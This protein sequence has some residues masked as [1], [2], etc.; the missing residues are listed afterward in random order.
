LT[1]DALVSAEVVIAN[2]SIVTASATSYPDLFWAL[3]GAGSSF[4]VVTEFKFQTHPAPD[5]NVIFNLDAPWTQSQAKDA[6]KAL[7]D[8]AVNTQ[9]TE[10]N[11]R[12]L[13]NSYSCSLGG[14]YYGTM[15]NFNTATSSIFSKI[16]VSA[17]TKSRIF[18]GGAGVPA[19][20][21]WIDSLNANAFGQMSSNFN[22]ETHEAFVCLFLSASPAA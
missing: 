3:R 17:N 16:G 11:M 8:W 7:Q 15:A 5:A 18:G 20:K 10:M 6:I 12:L 14:V 1:L 9:P 19:V 4:G 13:I 2:G 21:G 22:Y